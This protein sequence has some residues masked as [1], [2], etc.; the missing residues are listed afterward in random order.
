MGLPK[1][2][3]KR[4]RRSNP[5]FNRLTFLPIQ[6]RFGPGTNN[7]AELMELKL[8]LIFVKEKIITFLDLW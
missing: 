5:S 1:T 8:L 6:N 2:I 7:Y 3:L 4:W